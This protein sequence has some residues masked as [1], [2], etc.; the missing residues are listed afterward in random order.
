[1]DDHRAI[2]GIRADMRTLRHCCASVGVDDE[3]ARLR[4]A[5]ATLVSAAPL[6]PRSSRD[7][8]RDHRGR[9]PRRPRRRQ[10]RA[11]R[12]D[13]PRHR[14]LPSRG[15]GRPAAVGTATSPSGHAAWAR[16]GS[17]RQDSQPPRDRRAGLRP[18]GS[19]PA[20]SSPCSRLSA[21]LS[22]RCTRDRVTPSIRA[23][24]SCVATLDEV[25]ERHAAVAVALGDGY[26]EQE[27]RLDHRLLGA[28][29]ASCDAAGQIDPLLAVQPLGS[30]GPTQEVGQAVGVA[31]RRGTQAGEAWPAQ[32]P[33]AGGCPRRTRQPPP[34]RA[35]GRRASR[36]CS[37]RG[38]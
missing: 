37:R 12:R 8:R 36:R 14:P 19:S 15:A 21:S 4:D 13:G 11:G 30:P 1:M 9:R 29:C 34:P 35:S 3:V 25:G 31:A 17:P 20:P 38:T 18:G 23:I 22:I 26:H 27:V 33:R 7:D 32:A 10:Q 5:C 28:R 16:P 24:S 2:A 6:G